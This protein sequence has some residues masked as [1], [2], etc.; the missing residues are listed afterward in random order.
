VCA[1]IGCIAIEDGPIEELY[2]MVSEARAR[3]KRTCPST[4]SRGGWYAA[5][6]EALARGAP[7]ERGL[8]RSLEPGWRSSR[9]AGVRR[10]V[11][12][13]AKTGAYR[14]KRGN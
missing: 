6:L 5:G 11:S 3:M 9:S 8:L 4:S 2:V 12:V 1:S 13:D 14:V 10:G 7:E